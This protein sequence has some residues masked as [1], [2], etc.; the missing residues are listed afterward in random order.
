MK[1]AVA[2]VPEIPCAPGHE[3]R[4]WCEIF[5]SDTALHVASCGQGPPLVMLHG[6]GLSS[7]SW[8]H[9]VPM[10]AER[11]RVMSVDLQGFGGSRKPRNKPY[12]LLHQAG[13]VARL[14]LRHDLRDV[15][16]FGSSMGGGVALALMVG[17]FAEAVQRLR[18][19]VLLGSIAYRQRLP[20]YLELVRWRL[21]GPRLLGLLPPTLL[22]RK[23]LAFSY[24]DPRRLE[25]DAVAA[26]AHGLHSHDGRYALMQAVRQIVPDNVT[27]LT[28]R[29]RDIRLPVL[30]IYGTGDHIVPARIAEQLGQDIAGARLV[31]LQNCGHLPHEECPEDVLPIVKAFLTQLS[32][33]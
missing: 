27:T 14:I 21:V 33:G 7:Y 29:F 30:I 3:G 12:D 10:L 16:L 6:L 19:L 8:R 5:D 20:V 15:V 2:A 11:H 1:S 24:H 32:L 9:L 13:L 26:Y 22:M 4:C 17:D 23:V 25:A 28:T 18:G 31:R